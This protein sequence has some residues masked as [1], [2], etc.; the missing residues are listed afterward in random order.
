MKLVGRGEEIASPVKQLVDEPLAHC[1]RDGFG[2]G[3]NLHLAVDISHVKG[4]GVDAEREFSR[5]RF[6]V[7]AFD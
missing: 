7:V 4:D 3:V 5:S 1:F 6:V 2:F